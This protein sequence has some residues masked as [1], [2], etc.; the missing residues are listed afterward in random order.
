MRRNGNGA[1]GVGAGMGVMEEQG[2][3][4]R[5]CGRGG[6][7]WDAAMRAQARRG[8][9]KRGEEGTGASAGMGVADEQGDESAA[10]SKGAGARRWQGNQGARPCGQGVAT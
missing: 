9:H 2:Q 3:Q 6:G 5:G 8:G 10:T 4:I 7:R 1:S